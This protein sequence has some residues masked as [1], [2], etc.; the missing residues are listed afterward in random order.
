MLQVSTK[1]LVVDIKVAKARNKSPWRS[2]AKKNG[3]PK[4]SMKN[5]VKLSLLPRSTKRI[6]NEPSW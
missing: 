1:K 4:T 5:V 6:N 2:G 3:R